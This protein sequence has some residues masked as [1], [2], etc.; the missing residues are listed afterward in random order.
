MKF[1]CLVDK[2]Y[3][4]TPIH[5]EIYSE[6]T[7][8]YGQPIKVFSGDLMCNYQ[9]TGKTVLT[10]QKQL[11]QLTAQAFFVGDIC[12]DVPEITNG[13]VTVNGVNRD[14]FTGTKARNPDGTVN[15]VRIDIV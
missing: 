1:P 15:Y 2:R 10:A 12:P 13:M 4:K 7:D 11:V 5:V 14:I 3:C 9:S 8:R 6:D